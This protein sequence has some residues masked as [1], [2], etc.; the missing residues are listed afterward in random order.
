MSDSTDHPP[1]RSGGTQPLSRAELLGVFAFWTLMAVLT[2]ANRLADQGNASFSAVP[3]TVPIALAFQQMYV[4][5]LLTPL[6][7]WLAGRFNVEQSS[8]WAKLLIL[9]GIGIAIAFSVDLINS[10]LVRSF[11]GPPEPPPGSGMTRAFGGVGGP[12]GPA[13]QIG[14]FSVLRGPMILNHFIL[15]WGVLAAGFARDYFLRFRTHERETAQ[16]QA[17][18][19]QLQ[20][21]LAEAKLSALN[22]QL[23]P[24]FLFNTLHAVSS[25]VER[26]PRGVRRMIAR[27]SELLRYTLDG[28]NDTE[29][30]LTKEIEFLQ[31]YLEI[32]QIRFQ[33]QLEI[34]VQVDDDARDALVPSLI[35]QPLVENAVKHGVDKIS[36]KGKI[37]ITARRDGDRLVMTVAD[38]G[39]GPV[40]IAKL[41]DAGVGLANIRQRLEQLYGR[42]EGQGPG[43]TLAESPGGGGTVAQI[44]M[45]FRTRAELRTTV[46]THAEGG[47]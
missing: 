26:D 43:L 12:G 42:G 45:P 29:V 25:L 34:D 11:K 8:A 40:K 38:N 6:V 33:G 31:R 10:T 39:P 44:V 35:L 9:I 36:G 1:P 4:W 18:T 22:A 5:A 3:R 30:V 47:R 14:A 17:E 20:T 23:N 27:L 2:A 46:V 24:H 28:G 37:K 15:Y 7:F 41:D 32:M 19:A 16:L 21:Q 13:S